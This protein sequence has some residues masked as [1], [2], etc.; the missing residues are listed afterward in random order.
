M[1]TWGRV[2]AGVALTALVGVGALLAWRLGG[3]ADI[4]ATVAAA[5]MWAPLLFLGVHSLV[6]VSPFPRTIFTV[7]AGVLF[8]STAG[9]L[10]TVTA[11]MVSA[12]AAFWLVRAA[13]A[14]FVERHAPRAA[15]AWVGERV[16]RRGLLAMVSLRLIPMLPFSVVNY[17]SALSGVR[18]LPFLVGTLVGVLPGTVA[19]VVLGDAA[20]G[21]NP[22]PALLAVSVAGALVGV[23]GAVL[24][25]RRPEPVVAE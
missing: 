25:A 2:L 16:E 23:T 17:A 9:L 1:T 7:A 5:G 13:G 4:R 8:G 15:V 24:A 20:L 12:A 10:L 21:G 6:T 22:P 3:A 19:V 11:T 18:F 14:G